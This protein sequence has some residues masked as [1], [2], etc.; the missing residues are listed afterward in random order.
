MFTIEQ[1]KSIGKTD[2]FLMLLI[3]RNLAAA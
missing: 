3:L 1:K 2:G